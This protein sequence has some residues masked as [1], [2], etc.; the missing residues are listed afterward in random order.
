MGGVAP[1]YKGLHSMPTN[2]VSVRH[3][4]FT[5]TIAIRLPRQHVNDRL[6]TKLAAKI[7]WLFYLSI[8]LYHFNIYL[9]H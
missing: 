8:L 6:R 7:Q 2:L 9:T 1:P 3:L 4:F 5:A